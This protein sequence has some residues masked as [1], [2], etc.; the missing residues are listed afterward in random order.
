MNMTRINVIEPKQLT[1][2]HLMAEY[3]ELPMVGSALKRSI[4]SKNGVPKIPSKYTLNTGHVTFFYNLGAYLE[5]RYKS[6]IDELNNRG[7]KL[8]ENRIVDFDVFKDNGMYNDWNPDEP[9]LRINVE[10]IKQKLDMK[11]DWYKHYGK[12]ILDKHEVLNP[13]ELYRG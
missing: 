12:P 3:R 1:D 2:Q 7:Y 8:D 11:I 13:T 4:R 6:L 5:R 9:A 10:R